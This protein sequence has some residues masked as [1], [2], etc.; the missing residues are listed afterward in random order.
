LE[1][2]VGRVLLRPSMPRAVDVGLGVVLVPPQRLSP[3]RG[4]NRRRSPE[5]DGG[6]RRSKLAG[7]S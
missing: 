6:A 1:S 5:I 7:A 2:L 4:S 3:A